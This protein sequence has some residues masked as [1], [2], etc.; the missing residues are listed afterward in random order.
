MR[1]VAATL[2]VLHI[3][4]T[5]AAAQGSA[6]GRPVGGNTLE[7]VNSATVN[8]VFHISCDQGRNWDA[9]TLGAGATNT[10]YCMRDTPPPSMW[11]RI[12]TQ[13]PG[14][15]RFEVQGHS[16]GGR[17]ARSP[18]TRAWRDGLSGVCPA[19]DNRRAVASESFLRPRQPAG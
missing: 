17:V 1:Y 14:Q 6:T 13:V 2:L 10:F 9:M 12:I 5:L 18:G 3:S 16:S 4:V 8:I 11:F 19:R 15:Q 7:I